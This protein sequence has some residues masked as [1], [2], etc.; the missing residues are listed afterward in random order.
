[1]A[2]AKTVT[3][4]VCSG[5][6]CQT[7]MAGFGVLDSL[8]GHSEA[9]FEAWNFTLRLIMIQSFMHARTQAFMHS[10]PHVLTH[11]CTHAPPQGQAIV[12]EVSMMTWIEGYRFIIHL[13]KK[14]TR[15]LHL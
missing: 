12:L 1:M 6:E 4:E 8:Q 11:S 15:I 14:S 13:K 9:Q 10:C 5:F 7:V 2:D 3:F